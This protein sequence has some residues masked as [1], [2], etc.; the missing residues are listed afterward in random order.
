MNAAETVEA[1]KARLQA[2]HAG[3]WAGGGAETV[4][5]NLTVRSE[6]DALWAAIE[7][8]AQMID[9]SPVVVRDYFGERR[10]R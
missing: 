8:L 3:I 9:G 5:V 6:A 4:K 1:I 2:H 10:S 7:V